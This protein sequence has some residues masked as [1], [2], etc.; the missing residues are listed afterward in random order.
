MA[1]RRDF[2]AE[3]AYGS[4]FIAMVRK[5]QGPSTS[6]GMTKKVGAMLTDPSTSLLANTQAFISNTLSQNSSKF[7]AIADWQHLQRGAGQCP[8]HGLRFRN[9]L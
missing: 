5:T 1:D 6:L 8:I 3:I 7:L 4:L 2:V 9:R